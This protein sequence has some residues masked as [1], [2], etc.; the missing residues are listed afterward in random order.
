MG[1]G[2]AGG[3][4][5]GLAAGFETAGRQRERGLQAAQFSAQQQKQLRDRLSTQLDTLIAA[6]GSG[7]EAGKFTSDT[8]PP[9]LSQAQEMLFDNFQRALGTDAA[10]RARTTFQARVQGFS[11]PTER[12][13]ATREEAT[14]A[15]DQPLVTF[16][17]PNNQEVT[18]RRNDPLV[19]ELAAQDSGFVEKSGAPTVQIQLGASPVGKLVQD[20][21]SLLAQGF[22]ETHPAVQAIDRQLESIGRPS[23]P[24]VNIAEAGRRSMVEAAVNSL[25]TLEGIIFP[26]GPDGEMNRDAIFE[27]SVNLGSQGRLARANFD[28]LASVILRLE[29]GAQA[30]AEE[31]ANVARRFRPS[32][33]DDDIVVRDKL[34]RMQFRLERAIELSARRETGAP[35]A[36]EPNGGDVVSMTAAQVNSLS[37][38]EIATLDVTQLDPATRSLVAA[39]IRQIRGATR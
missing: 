35:Q 23:E 11:G 21:A 14:A 13:R 20:R 36:T 10:A 25:G 22:D 4:A 16:V 18:L 5:S 17:G 7:I 29:T 38:D 39:R 19:D 33:L 1:A 30:N 9:A 27:M 2:F 6:T 12:G 26:N 32:I 8:V 24:A 31:I 3:L 37:P 34:A 28:D 15:G